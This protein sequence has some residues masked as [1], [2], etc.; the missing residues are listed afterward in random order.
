MSEI[1]DQILK[2]LEPVQLWG[3]NSAMTVTLATLTDTY[4]GLHRVSTFLGQVAETRLTQVIGL[5]Q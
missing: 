3:A 2:D 1:L 4:F 5:Q